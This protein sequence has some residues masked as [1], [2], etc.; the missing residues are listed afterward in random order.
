MRIR[1][2]RAAAPTTPTG[3]VA[4]PTAPARRAR[5]LCGAAALGAMLTLAGCGVQ[6]QTQAEPLPSGVLQIPTPIPTVSPTVRETTVFFVSGRELEG[7]P[8]SIEDRSANGVME[9]L[10]AGPPVAKQAELRTLLRDPLTGAPMLV[11][12]SVTPSGQVVLRRTDAYP[13]LPA[14]DQALLLG[15]VVHSMNEVGLDEVI[16]TDESGTA[17]PVA[18]PDGRIK[19]GPVTAED[20]EILLGE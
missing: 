15:Q 18:L 9:A 4:A 1:R 10:A 12:T 5:R 17:L 14:T 2:V 20:F 11:V 16:I 3:R 13:L 7:V 19:E 6:L 8:E